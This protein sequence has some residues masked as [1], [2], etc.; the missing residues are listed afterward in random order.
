MRTRRRFFRE[1]N[2]T[3]PTYK[4]WF[5]IFKNNGSVA[6][7]KRNI[8]NDN[9]L[10]DTIGVYEFVTRYPKSS[11]RKIASHFNM[12]RS[13]VHRHNCRIWSEENPHEFYES[14]RDSPKIEADFKYMYPGKELQLLSNWHLFFEKLLVF[15][16]REINNSRNPIFQDLIS[17]LEQVDLTEGLMHPRNTFSFEQLQ[18]MDPGDVFDIIDGIGDDQAINS[19]LWGDS[20]AED[21]IMNT[22]LPSQ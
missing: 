11:I 17:S 1:F 16:R 5:N 2:K 14:V 7:K 18:A 3:A 13:K 15:K 12:S 21:N 22:S 20:E 10:H 6:R 4:T 9:L 8:G 19:D